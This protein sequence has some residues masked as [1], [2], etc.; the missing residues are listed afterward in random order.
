MTDSEPTSKKPDIDW[1][2][3]ADDARALFLAT[4][5]AVPTAIR[6]WTTAWCD[7]MK[8]AAQTQD[9]LARRWNSIVREPGRGGDVLKEMRE[10]VKQY[11]VE[12][13]AIP[14]RSVL[15]FLTS[16]Q[17]S[18]GSPATP[19]TPGKAAKPSPDDDFEKAMDKFV[20]AAADTLSQFKMTSVLQAKA[21]GVGTSAAPAPDL[22]DL[23]KQ[24]AVLYAARDNFKKPPRSAP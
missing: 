8:S 24:V 21:P 7:W 20:R 5:G 1:K 3:Y 10:D 14:E 16:V 18:A 2:Q 22:E 23:Q 19:A 9:Q 13:V 6:V 12:V 11:L 17:E 15:E 4:S